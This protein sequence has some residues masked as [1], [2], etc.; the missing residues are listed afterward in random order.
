M[1]RFD[2]GVKTLVQKRPIELFCV[3]LLLP[4][5]PH[6][7]S[8]QSRLHVIVFLGHLLCTWILLE[9]DALLEHPPRSCERSRGKQIIGG[10]PRTLLHLWISLEFSLS[11][12]NVMCILLEKSASQ[13]AIC[14]SYRESRPPGSTIDK[15]KLY[16]WKSLLYIDW[17]NLWNAASH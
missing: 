2:W 15:E 7:P 13:K 12:Q 6:I 3:K 4:H 10:Y 17:Y 1:D 14:R 8:H 9:K 5:T 16:M 11:V